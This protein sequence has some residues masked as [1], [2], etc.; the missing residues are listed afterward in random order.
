MRV[1]SPPGISENY[2]DAARKVADKAIRPGPE[3]KMIHYQ[4]GVTMDP[5]GGL[6]EASTDKDARRDAGRMF[7]KFR[8]PWACAC[9]TRKGAFLRMANT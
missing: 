3:P 7:I 1:L 5:N 2:L 8:Q 9:S 6:G 4:A